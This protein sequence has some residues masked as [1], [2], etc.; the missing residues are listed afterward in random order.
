MKQTVG[1]IFLITSVVSIFMARLKKIYSDKQLYTNKILKV[2][3]LLQ[4]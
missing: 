1:F 4:S 3:F 2:N